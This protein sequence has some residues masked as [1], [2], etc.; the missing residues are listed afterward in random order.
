MAR[1]KDIEL[2][3]DDFKLEL[4]PIVESKEDEIVIEEA[5]EPVAEIRKREEPQISVDDGIKALRAELEQERQARFN[6]ERQARDATDRVNQANKEVG[7]SQL[8]EIDN[9]IDIIKRNEQILKQNL[10]IALAEQDVDRVADIQGEIATSAVNKLQL[11]QG[12]TAYEQRLRE[13]PKIE[14][15]RQDPVDVLA[16]QLTPRSAD[17]VRRHPEYARDPVLYQR[18]VAA[19]TLT[20]IDRIAPDTDEYFEAIENT[21]R[22]N[23]KESDMSSSSSNFSSQKARAAPPAAPVSRQPTNASGTRPNV[24]RL[25]SQEREMA[26]MMGM[27]DQEYARNK[28]ALIKEGKLN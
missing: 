13:T 6:A 10:R 22:I 4:D 3:E 19:H 20:E 27:T 23:R 1:A 2:P 7:D 26:S 17:W 11:E 16:S 24:V 12:R 9:A 18:M 5:E 28:V 14:Q 21:L 8:R 25:T 15:I